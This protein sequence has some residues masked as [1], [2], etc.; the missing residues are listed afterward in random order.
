MR[1]LCCKVNNK[2]LIPKNHPKKGYNQNKLIALTRKPSNN[3]RRYNKF[4]QLKSVEKSKTDGMEFIS[5][6]YN[7]T[8]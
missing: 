4:H 2:I 6:L 8:V 3:R 5:Y 1:F 7:E